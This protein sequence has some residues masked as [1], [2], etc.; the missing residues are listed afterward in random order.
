MTSRVTSMDIVLD[1]ETTGKKPGC[2]VISIGAY[3]TN[4]QYQFYTTIW[5]SA[6]KS[7]YG[8][9]DDGDTLRWWDKQSAEARDEAFSGTLG[10]QSALGN[11]TDWL[12]SLPA[13]NVYVW[14]NGADFDQPILSYAYDAVGMESP[15]GFNNRCYRTLKNLYKHI[16]APD[17]FEGIKHH[18][19]WDAKHEAKH[20]SRLLDYHYQGLKLHSVQD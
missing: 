3:S 2:P 10:L 7:M 20:L 14:G 8:L 19:L 11:F 13:N 12:N 1:I 9:K 17:D 18:A 16:K 15:F 6:Q 5:H 4:L